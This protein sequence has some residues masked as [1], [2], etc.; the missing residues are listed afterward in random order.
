MEQKTYKPELL[1]RRGELT[2]WVLSVFSLLGLFFLGMAGVSF[3]IANF[4]VGF[5]FFAATSISLGN[6]MDRRTELTMDKEGVYF[7]NGLRRVSSTWQNI[8]EVR[9]FPGTTG[10]TV[11]VLTEGA[12]FEFKTLGEMKYAGETRARTGFLEGA[13]LIGIILDKAGLVEA[14][15]STFTRYARP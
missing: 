2:A 6:W 5:L 12:Y 10:D 8:R 14:E 1:P 13:R 15:R 9:V 3:W 4:F 7:S 11:Q